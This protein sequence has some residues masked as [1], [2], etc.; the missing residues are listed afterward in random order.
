MI[1][2]NIPICLTTKQNRFNT[3]AQKKH[4]GILNLA[5]I[6]NDIIYN[7]KPWMLVFYISGD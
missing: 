4:D 1:L 7:H 6:Y 3:S 2:H 5:D